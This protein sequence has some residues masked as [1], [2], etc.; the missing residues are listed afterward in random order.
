MELGEG[1]ALRAGCT[2]HVL[3]PQRITFYLGERDVVGVIPLWSVNLIV[4]V[5][6]DSNGL[7]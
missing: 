4:V 2:S 1:A 3:S 7:E 6:T 5:A